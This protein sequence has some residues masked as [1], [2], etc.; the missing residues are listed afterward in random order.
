MSPLFLAIPVITSL[1]HYD[2]VGRGHPRHQKLIGMM[3]GDIWVTSKENKGS[4]FGFS[5]SLPVERPLNPDL[6]R[7]PSGLSRVMI[8]EGHMLNQDILDK[9]FRLLGVETVLC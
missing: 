9:Q 7:L 3:G 6:F 2:A 1:A 4:C 5:L 8:V